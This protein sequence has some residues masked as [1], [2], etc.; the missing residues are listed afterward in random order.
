MQV[1]YKE[2]SCWWVQYAMSKSHAS[3]LSKLSYNNLIY[4]LYRNHMFNHTQS[5][6]CSLYIPYIRSSLIACC[7]CKAIYISIANDNP[8]RLFAV[9]LSVSTASLTHSL[10]FSLSLSVSLPIFCRLASVV[11][12]AAASP[13][14]PS[15]CLACYRRQVATYASMMWTSSKFAQMSCAPDYR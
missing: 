1:I 9:S 8:C 11:A 14:W 4:N 10:S 15:P 5:L 2:I 3:N 6:I 12:P 7:T 13:R